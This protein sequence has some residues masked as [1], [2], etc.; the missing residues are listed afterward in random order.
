MRVRSERRGALVSEVI[1]V[2][3]GTANLASV[4][5]A[6][7]RVGAAPRLSTDASV[8]AAAERVV[9]PGVGAFGAGMARL[10][11]TGLAV[12]LTKRAREGRALLCVC[13]GLQL[14]CRESEESPGI[15]GLGVIDAAVRRFEDRAGLVVPQ[16]GWNLVEP[17]LDS[18]LLASGHAYFANSYRLDALPAGYSGA[19]AVHGSPFVAALEKGA[20]LACQFHPELSGAWG[21][22]LLG[23]W[24]AKVRAC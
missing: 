17:A 20:L 22:A 19:L 16:L 6:L 14:L 12:A 13:L 15:S 8:V 11:A 2:D 23:R 10:E 18:T 9:L 3:T 1:V 4:C 7:V 24:L 5:A 21:H